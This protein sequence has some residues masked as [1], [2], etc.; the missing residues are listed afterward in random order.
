MLDRIRRRAR[1]LAR[2]GCASIGTVYVLVGVL[3]LLAL[4]GIL[5]GQADEDRMIYVVLDVPGGAF[6]VWAVIAGLLGYM[7]WR[8]VEALT[9][10]HELGADTVGVAKRVGIAVSASAYGAL[11]FSAARIALGGG[12]G[13]G[14]AS[15]REQE[16]LVARVL[17]WPAGTWLVALTGLIVIGVAIGQ[18]VIVSRSGY[19]RWINL[20]GCAEDMRRVIRTV[21]WYGYAA[22]ATILAVLGWFFLLAAFRHDPGAVGDTDTAFDFIGGGV[23]GDS[24]FFLVAVGT[25]A[26]GIFMFLN[27]AFYQFRHVRRAEARQAGTEGA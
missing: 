5:T 26:Y 18:I 7:L 1:P 25:I 27:A 14:D 21:A 12:S 23:I 17:E 22:R 3:A 10:P 4:G 11:A 16:R 9:D 8:L 24:A 20:E 6:L 13:G 19:S 15:E 2:Y